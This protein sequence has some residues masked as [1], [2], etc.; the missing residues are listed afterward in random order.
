MVAPY[1]EIHRIILA[2]LKIL[3]Y[4]NI[5]FSSQ[6]SISPDTL[7]SGNEADRYFTAKELKLSFLIINLMIISIIFFTCISERRSSPF[8]CIRQG[9]LKNNITNL[10]FLKARTSLLLTG[11]GTSHGTLRSLKILIKRLSLIS[12]PNQSMFLDIGN[13]GA[14]DLEYTD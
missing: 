5:M 12:L 6:N 13:P 11:N 7:E 3:K 10:A 4:H 8:S 2:N 9:T 1:D 14:L